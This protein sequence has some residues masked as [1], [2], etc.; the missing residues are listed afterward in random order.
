MKDF[1]LEV[2]SSLPGPARTPRFMP[3]TKRA[4]EPPQ[5]TFKIPGAL[6][7]L[8]ITAK[9]TNRGRAV[10]RQIGL[11]NSRR[12]RGRKPTRSKSHTPSPGT[13]CQ[14]RARK[15]TTVRYHST[16]SP[17]IWWISKTS[18]S[19]WDLNNWKWPDLR[20]CASGSRRTP[21]AR[22]RMPTSRE[23]RSATTPS[24]RLPT[25]LTLRSLT[26]TRTG[27]PC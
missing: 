18:L 14:T 25:R 15:S 2:L 12:P 11:L 16:T 26:F 19:V 13:S 4:R 8:I 17:P 10:R 27:F 9:P 23:S 1:M 5:T 7:A 3:P 24:W 6:H 21:R 20:P 22:R